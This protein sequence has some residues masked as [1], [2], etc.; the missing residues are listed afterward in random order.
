M[1]TYTIVPGDTMWSIAQRYGITLNDLLMANPHISN[2]S[3]I[4]TGQ[5]INI[6]NNNNS[7]YTVVSGDTMWN[8]AQR[9]RITL[10][11][12]L[13]ANPKITS[14]TLIL[15]G[16]T[17]NIP[18]VPSGPDVSDNMRPLETEVIRLVNIEREKAG[19]PK[20][21]ENNELNRIARTKSQDFINNNYFGHN[22]P[23]YGS[24]F[25]MLR[26][27]RVEFTAAGENIASGQRTA[28]EVMNSWMNSTEHRANIL[29]PTYNKI[30]VGAVRDDNGNTFWTQLFIRS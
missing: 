19:I 4:L 15:P 29:N 5:T 18:T 2:P 14:P 21:S 11:E 23:T 17:I 10:N 24:P 12:L 7:T 16:Q 25:E 26:T 28:T 30:G 27:L 20:L 9:Y 3:L 1:T 8:I 6:P 13:M 22:S